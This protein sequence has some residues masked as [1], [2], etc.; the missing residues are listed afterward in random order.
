MQ[1]LEITNSINTTSEHSRLRK[2]GFIMAAG[3]I[4]IF[5][6][7]PFVLGS[8]QKTTTSWWP[9]YTAVALTIISLIAPLLLKPVEKGWL[10]LGKILG[11]INTY[12]V[13]AIIYL[14]IFTPYAII[15]H[16][17]N[18]NLLQLAFEPERKS[19]RIKSRQPKLKNFDK[20]Y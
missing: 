1:I 20:P 7:L 8:E 9:W 16:L 14:V 13:L 4:I 11:K 12:I 5:K 17:L 10:L 3:I 18:K 2:F 19:Y 15:L 6:L